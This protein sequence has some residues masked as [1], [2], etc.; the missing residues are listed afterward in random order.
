MNICEEISKI[1][2]QLG[3]MQDQ[4]LGLIK[5]ERKLND[6]AA[7]ALPSR[8][9]ADMDKID[10]L[11]ESDVDDA[12]FVDG[13]ATVA[14]SR[15]GVQ[16]MIDLLTLLAHLKL[17]RKRLG[18]RIGKL[19]ERV[20]FQRE[21]DERTAAIALKARAEEAA[22]IV[23]GRIAMVLGKFFEARLWT[24]NAVEKLSGKV[25]GI[26][27]KGDERLRDAALK[28]AAK[29]A[30]GSLADQDVRART[31]RMTISTTGK[32]RVRI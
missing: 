19:A 7:G 32:R 9:L 1:Q 29:D 31:G 26:F 30:I 14:R 4:V 10:G 23:D 18:V 28:N 21:G 6:V 8:L 15:D 27:E 16:R 20:K 12:A 11:E 5:L 2:A 17:S 13:L 3:H 24:L 25:V 22:A